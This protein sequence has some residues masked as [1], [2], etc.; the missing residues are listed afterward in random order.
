M[1]ARI[2]V[3]WLEPID[4][5]IHDRKGALSFPSSNLLASY[6]ALV[7]TALPSPLVV[8]MASTGGLHIAEAWVSRVAQFARKPSLDA[9]RRCEIGNQFRSERETGNVSWDLKR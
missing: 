5:L 9:T 1:R 2:F 4:L 8:D 6:G 7:G 3:E